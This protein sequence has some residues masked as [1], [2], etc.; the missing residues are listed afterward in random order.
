[1]A[2]EFF[3]FITKLLEPTLSTLVQSYLYPAQKNI[4]QKTYVANMKVIIIFKKEQRL[5]RTK[6]KLTLLYAHVKI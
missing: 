1:M 4:Q 3:V 6:N 2:L 5:R